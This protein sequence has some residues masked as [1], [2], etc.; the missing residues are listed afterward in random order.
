MGGMFTVI[1]VREG[2]AAND[3]KDPGPY[4]HPAGTVA[5]EFK[6]KIGEAPQPNGR[7]GTKKP[8]MEMPMGDARQ[9][10]KSQRSITELEQGT[11]N[12]ANHPYNLRRPI[13]PRQPPGRSR[14]QA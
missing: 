13:Y 10:D 11:S 3:Y 8:A 2:L 7:A 6:D 14:A 1:K 12:E 9:Q 4:D 5:Y